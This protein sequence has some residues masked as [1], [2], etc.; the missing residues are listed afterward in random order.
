MSFI[1]VIN[2]TMKFSWMEEHWT[3]EEC[4]D[5]KKW[6]KEAVS[7]SIPL[8]SVWELISISSVGRVQDGSPICRV[9]ANCRNSTTYLVH[10]FRSNARTSSRY[11]KS[12]GTQHQSPSISFFKRRLNHTLRQH[13]FSRKLYS[14]RARAVRTFSRRNSE[15]RRA[16]SGPRDRILYLRRCHT[17]CR[18]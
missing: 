12:S 10:S 17:G 16:D 14:A 11:Y 6:L 2:P 15:T 5:A 18:W 1:S 13:T 4:Q 7:I 3:Q 8:P 9:S